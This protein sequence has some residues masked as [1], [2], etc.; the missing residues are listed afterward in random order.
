[1][2]LVPTLDDG[3]VRLRPVDLE[4]DV[5]LALPWYRDPVVLWGAEGT[6]EPFACERI[7]RM[8]AVLAERGEVYIVEVI[9]ERGPVAVGDAALNPYGVPIVIGDA[10]W[11][12]RGVGRRVLGLLV[13]RARALGYRE[14]QAH[15]VYTDNTASLR[16]YQGAGFQVAGEGREDGR[17]FVRLTLRLPHPQ[18][19]AR[20]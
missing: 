13:D 4:R 10:S 19:G 5:R 6:R 12:G 11:R 2:A 17:A 15:Q 18:G 16:L 8:Y 14:V 3:V 20:G 9:T 7:A 1:M